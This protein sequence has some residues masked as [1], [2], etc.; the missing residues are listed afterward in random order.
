M[1]FTTPGITTWAPRLV[2]QRYRAWWYLRLVEIPGVVCAWCAPRLVSQRPTVESY[3]CRTCRY[4]TSRVAVNLGR[5]RYR[6]LALGTAD[7]WLLDGAQVGARFGSSPQNIHLFI[8]ATQARPR[9]ALHESAP[10]RV[11]TPRCYCRVPKRTKQLSSSIEQFSSNVSRLQN[12][13][14]K[15]KETAK[16]FL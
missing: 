12:Y 1:T 14:L 11:Q 6:S 3:E 5:A 8:G 10:Y 16:T 7:H 2:S 4:R 9:A 13:I 15:H